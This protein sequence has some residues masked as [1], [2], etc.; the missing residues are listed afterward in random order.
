MKSCIGKVV[1]TTLGRTGTGK[2]QLCIVFDV[3]DETVPYYQLFESDDN[4]DFAARALSA[5][6]WDP[7]ANLWDMKQL[8]NTE[9]LIGREARVVIEDHEWNGETKRRVKYV[10]DMMKGGSGV[11]EQLSDADT[12]TLAAKLRARRAAN[13]KI[14]AGETP[15]F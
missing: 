11:R 5:L 10:N 7:D 3:G 6:G 4:L 14:P 12:I 1:S 8:H 13:L 15:P 2:D 9:L